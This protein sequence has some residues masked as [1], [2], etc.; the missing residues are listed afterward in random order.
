MTLFHGRFSHAFFIMRKALLPDREQPYIAH[1]M[2]I[3]SYIL[4]IIGRLAI[5]PLPMVTSGVLSR[6][7]DLQSEMMTL[8]KT[9]LS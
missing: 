5:P 7:L 4:V 3:K 6:V 9:S 2:A 8:S 1:S